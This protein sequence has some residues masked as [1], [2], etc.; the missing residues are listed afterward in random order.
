MD[1]N[2]LGSFLKTRRAKVSPTTVNLPAG[3]RRRVPG[4][5]RDEVARLSGISIDYYTEIEQGRATHPSP[6]VLA[7]L[8]RCLRLDYDEQAYLYGLAECAMPPVADPRASRSLLDLLNRLAD[9]PAMIITDLH[10]VLVQNPLAE[11]LL[12]DQTEWTAGFAYQWFTNT[13]VR[14]IYP[15]RDHGHHSAI[16]VA[17]LRIAVMRRRGDVESAE[18]VARL[19]ELS[20]EFAGLWRRGDVS[21]RHRVRKRI[22]HASLGEVDL[23]C[24]RVFSSDERQRLLWFSADDESVGQAKLESLKLVADAF[25]V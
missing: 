23:R 20:N 16:L 10:Q 6:Q 21:I 12:G 14:R 7:A 15:E 17:D 24:D 18:L 8:S 2:E 13:D 22:L 11:A 5:R 4:L 3:G 25:Q 1:G 9:T 19:T